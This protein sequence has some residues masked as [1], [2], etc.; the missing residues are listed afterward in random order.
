[1][2]G[3]PL[4]VEELHAGYGKL[5]ILYGVSVK[6]KPGELVAIVGPNGSGK[7]TLLKTIFGFTTVYRGRIILGGRDITKIP[8]SR[9]PYLGLAY[10]PQVDNIF[11]RLT[12]EENL[13]LSRIVF[14]ERYASSPSPQ[15]DGA[16]PDKLFEDMLEEIYNMFPVLRERRKQ[17]AGTLSGGE[18]QMLAIARALLMKPQVLLLDEPTA[19]LAPKIAEEIFR[20]IREIADRGVTVL[21]VEQNARRA[22]EIADRGYILVQG[23]VAYE[24]PSKEILS[25]P[26]L[27]KLYLGISK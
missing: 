2:N 26:E 16:S 9:K 18:R 14:R 7:S 27:S 24:G 13:K 6:A 23:R 25:H 8:P 17:K 1:M 12:V 22:L 15:K 3:L 21:L 4:V 11:A 19:A 5:Q 20:K 10:V